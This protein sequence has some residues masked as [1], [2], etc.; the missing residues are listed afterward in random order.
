MFLMIII[1]TLSLLSL[2][3]IT[4]LYIF[5]TFFETSLHSIDDI[6][7]NHPITYDNIVTLFPTT[8]LDELHFDLQFDNS[9]CASFLLLLLIYLIHPSRHGSTSL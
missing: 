7:L 3:L 8:I 9:P 4:M 2:L 5:F 1:L 6:S